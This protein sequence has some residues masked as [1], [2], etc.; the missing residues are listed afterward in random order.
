MPERLVKL[1]VVG[2]GVTAAAL[3]VRGW[4]RGMRADE[5]DVEGRQRVPQF[6]GISAWLNT[7]R[8]LSM[9]DLRGQ[10]VLIDFWTYCCINCL[11]IQPDLRY[12]EDKYAGR[13]FVVVGVHSGKFVQEK[14]ADN[15]RQAILR[16]DIRHPVAVDSNYATWNAFGVRAWPTLALIDSEGYVIGMV[17]GEGHR[18]DLDTAIAHLLELGRQRGTLA[19]PLTFQREVAPRKTVLEF[20]GK[21]LADP[22]RS[23]LFIADTGHNRIVVTDLGGQIQQIIGSGQPGRE[24]D[25]FRGPQGMALSEDGA[26]LYV[27]DTENHAIRA[28]NL[29]LGVVTRI[30]GTG[31]Q[32]F[33]YRADG[34]G[35]KTAVSSPWDLARVGEKLYIAMAGT[36]QIWVMDLA[37]RL[38]RAYAGTGG[39]GATDGASARA[40]FAQPSG[41]AT[42]GQTLYV[43]DSEASSIRAI[44]LGT[45]QTRT[46]AGSGELFDFGLRDGPGNKALFQHPLGVAL[47]EGTL[48]VAD[49]FNSVIRAIDVES[50][51]VETW[52]G[53][54]NGEGVLKLYE[55]GG[56]G[57]AGD[58]LYIADTNHH[59]VVEV[60]IATRGWRELGVEPHTGSDDN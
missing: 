45:S 14:D 18:D 9:K 4:S 30:A 21:V 15:I 17:S 56:L 22:A 13:P 40:T 26:T 50:G 32:G 24:E 12:L 29:P 11:H 1:A 46:L 53:E 33:N 58:R 38:V 27:A 7:E 41:L 34:P 48:F 31:E 25:S 10:V 52:L 49:T 19:K 20:P 51:R 5:M 8:P 37:T 36:H 16:H 43:A 39:E 54:G 6:K 42:D 28:V 55:P 57:V 23:R 44:D 2:L 59:R 35:P 60:E 47:H 3:A